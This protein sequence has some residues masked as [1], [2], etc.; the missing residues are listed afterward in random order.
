V[1]ATTWIDEREDEARALDEGD[2][3][4]GAR[5]SFLLPRD[6]TTSGYDALAYLAG[7]S[8]GPQPTGAADDV[9]R[10]LED[11]ATRVVEGHWSARRPWGDYHVALRAPMA[12]VVGAHDDE[13][14]VMNSLTVNLHL[15]LASFYRPTADRYR[16]VIEDAAFPSDSYAV[17]S[18][19]AF[20]GFDPD[21][22]VVR[23]RP[24]DGERTLRTEDV[25]AHLETASD[26]TA[27]LLLGGVNYLTGQL[28]DIPGI[29]S[30]ARDRGITVGWDLAHAAGNVEL[31]LHDW[32]PDFAAWCTYKYLNGGPGST[33]AAWVHERHL[34]DETLPRLSGWWGTDPSVRFEML[35]KLT[36]IASADAWAVSNPPILS[37]TPLVSALG[38]FEEV[39]MGAIRSRSVRL[40]AYLEQ[41]LVGERGEGSLRLVT[42]SDPAA[43]GCQLSVSV[44]GALPEIAASLRTRHGV[45]CDVRPPDVV[46][47]APA[48]LFCT[49]HDC[50]RAARALRETVA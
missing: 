19:A 35:A 44:A 37:M 11:W 48:P 3:A 13:V 15:L 29:T 4:G 31:A 42:P 32:G 28:M 49:F 22:A 25:V 21:D 27:L 7:N 12:R 23:L 46:R 8:L 47:L 39:G 38:V 5:A 50:W 30:A 16:I 24:R 45:V 9:R 14:V 40:T 2:A 26:R 20:R 18:H 33:A 1:T 41:L 17:R 36:P 6:D 43:R 10:E 34:G